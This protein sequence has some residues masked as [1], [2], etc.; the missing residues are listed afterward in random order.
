M[1]NI[2]YHIRYCHKSSTF[3]I[4]L[5]KSPNKIIRVYRSTKP[6]LEQDSDHPGLWA[7][8]SYFKPKDVL[9]AKTSWLQN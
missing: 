8:F 3:Y 4:S 9:K 6:C 1:Y 2:V 7:A 5:I